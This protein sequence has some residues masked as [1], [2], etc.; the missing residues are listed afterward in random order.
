MKQYLPLLLFLPRPPYPLLFSSGPEKI[1]YLSAGLQPVAQLNQVI[2]ILFA[3]RR[4]SG[5]VAAASRAL[6][7]GGTRFLY[8]KPHLPQVKFHL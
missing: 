8:R 2:S 3:A 7:N 5:R 1:T 4:G 6:T